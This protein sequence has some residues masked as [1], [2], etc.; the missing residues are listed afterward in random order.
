[1]ALWNQRM[2]T[3]F[4]DGK[5]A[6]VV[7]RE[8]YNGLISGVSLDGTKYFYVNPLAS[9]GAH[10]RQPWFDCAC[11]PPNVVRWIPQFAGDAY[12][13]DDDGGAIYVN[14]FVA[15]EA[16]VARKAGDV[17]LKQTTNYP[18]DGKVRI[19][20]TPPQT[21]ATF[22]VHVRI[23][24]WCESGWKVT[25]NGRPDVDVGVD[26]G[27]A[28]ISRQ[29]DAGDVIEVDLPMPV[30]RVYAD[31]RVTDDV[32][33][34]AL[35]RGP[36]VYCLEGVDHKDVNG[37]RVRNLVLPKDAE[38]K[39]EHR[40]DLLGGVTVLRGRAIAVSDSADATS[41]K[42]VDFTAVPY[43]AWDNREPG[44]MVVWFPEQRELAEAKP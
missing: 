1:M 23:P 9:T 27:S 6:D 38:L 40:P 32:G 24:S 22:N 19:D 35:M 25:V 12:A 26:K 43:Y 13:T 36:V 14:Q 8:A 10:H 31:P 4:G 28:I 37:G 42:P 11:C 2:A 41:D 30:R 20:V 44:E 16:K 21:G 18:W 3:L 39:A 34:V 7:E 17:T 33:R 5:Y 29:W 15:G